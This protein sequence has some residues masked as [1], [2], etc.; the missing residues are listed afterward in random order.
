MRILSCQA[1]QAK[2]DVSKLLLRLTKLLTPQHVTSV[3]CIGGAHLTCLPVP[4]CRLFLA[5]F[6]QLQLQVLIAH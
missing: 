4:S 1:R 5:A 3:C 6:D 2:T